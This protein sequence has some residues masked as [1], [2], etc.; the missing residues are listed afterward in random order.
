MWKKELAVAEKAAEAA[1]E[2]LTGLFGKVRRIQ[3]KG[4]IDLVTEADLRAEKAI[5]E[6]IRKTFPR[7]NILSEEAGRDRRTSDRTWVVDPLDGTVN[8]AHGFPFYAVSIA[9][10]IEGE[11][12]VGVVYAPPTGEYFEASKDSGVGFNPSIIYSLV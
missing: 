3:K 8:F 4:K 7:D 9:L 12:V 1:G 2:I 10:E 11:M 6:I 5:L